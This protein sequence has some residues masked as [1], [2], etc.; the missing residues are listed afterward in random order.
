MEHDKELE[1]EILSK[2]NKAG[3]MPASEFKKLFGGSFDDYTV[4]YN[5]LINQSFLTK[6]YDGLAEIN[7][8]ISTDI[9]DKGKLRLKGLEKE[10]LDEMN[11]QALQYKMSSESGKVSGWTVVIGIATLIILA[12]T[13][14]LIYLAYN[15]PGK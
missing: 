6:T 12:A 11:N 9:N 2:H 8:R 1:L 4:I 10:K 14:F 13:L 7:V 3:K 5:N 15:P